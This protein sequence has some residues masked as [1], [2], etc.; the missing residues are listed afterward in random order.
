MLS[1]SYTCQL[2][3]SSNVSLP[4]IHSL[5]TPTRSQSVRTSPK[6]TFRHQHRYSNQDELFL[7]KPMESSPAQTDTKSRFRQIASTSISKAWQDK[8]GVNSRSVPFYATLKQ[9]NLHH[10]ATT[11]SATEHVVST[12]IHHRPKSPS[13]HISR[14]QAPTASGITYPYQL[15]F[16][17]I[18]NLL[19]P[20]GITQ[21][22]PSLKQS[23]LQ[24]KICAT[25]FDTETGRFFGKTWISPVPM[26]VHTGKAQHDRH[27]PQTGG[28]LKTQNTKIRSNDSSQ[29]GFSDED[30]CDS[31][32]SRGL[33]GIPD[34]ANLISHRVT[35]GASRICLYFHTPVKS[36]HVAIA[37][38]FVFSSGYSCVNYAKLSMSFKF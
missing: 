23:L 6:Y 9:Q 8:L 13:K 22:S 12:P 37:I 4:N 15:A 33:N 1:N 14:V 27:S 38:E 30:S 10:P 19:L 7:N 32:D 25:L 2:K 17:T 35:V 28:S 31:S 16:S 36:P 18:E 20:T 5:S 29:N 11:S 34:G 3:T 21:S 26:T 24:L